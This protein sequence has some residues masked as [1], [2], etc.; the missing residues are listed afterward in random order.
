[1]K[2]SMTGQ[3]KGELLIQA[4]AWPG[5][6]VLTFGADSVFAG[7]DLLVSLVSSIVYNRTQMKNII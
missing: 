7:T 4:T 6:T 5:L 3:E 2:F 1:M